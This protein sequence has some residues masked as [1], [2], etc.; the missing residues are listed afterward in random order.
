MI[1]LGIST[2]AD[3]LLPVTV[4][5]TEIEYARIRLGV[6]VLPVV[7]GGARLWS[8]TA[9]RDEALRSAATSLDGRG[10]LPGGE[11]HPGLGTCLRVLTR[12]SWELA[13]RSHDGGAVTR[14]CIAADQLHCTKATFDSANNTYTLHGIDV[15]P[16]DAV[17]R[18][19]G[20]SAAMAIAALNAPTETLSAAFDAGPHAEMITAALMNAGGSPAEAARLAGAVVTCTG[21]TEIVGTTRAFGAAHRHRAIVTVY[22]T[23][24]GRLVASSSTSA[25]GTAWSSISSGTA[26]RLRQAVNTLVALLAEPVAPTWR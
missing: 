11:I 7:L 8:T 26:H 14:L 4:S 5:A 12:P 15:E 16:A 17:A 25:D 19:L 6:D 3:A 24:H 21:F 20:P 1:D 10:L 23:A 13:L 2:G 18:A 22:D 9:E